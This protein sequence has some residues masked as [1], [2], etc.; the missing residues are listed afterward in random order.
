MLVIEGPDHV[1]KTTSAMVA[2]R[3]SG[4]AYRHLSKPHAEW[5]YWH[6]YLNMVQ[7]SI[8]QDRFHLGA[9]VYGL[10]CGLH[11]VGAHTMESLFDLHRILTK[12]G[13]VTCIM[14]AEEDSWLRDHLQRKMKEE[15]YDS[16]VI[17][18]ANRVFRLLTQRGQWC[19]FCWPVD[20]NGWPSEGE[21]KTW[22]ELTTRLNS[23]K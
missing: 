16:E 19:D 22:V 8:I 20:V 7:P 18:E 5:D 14:Y 13:V 15:M 10:V 3:S 23:S 1:G 9:V 17:V 4:W 12:R 21:V 11:E 6:D 2:A